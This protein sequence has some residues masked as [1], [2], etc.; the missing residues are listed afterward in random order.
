MKK[1][2]LAAIVLITGSAALIA[3][4]QDPYIMGHIT[5]CSGL[6]DN[7]YPA[8]STNWF[9]RNQHR[10]V[11]YWAYILFAASGAGNVNM[12]NKYFL[13]KNPYELYSGSANRGREDGDN[14]SFENRWISPSGKLICEKILNWSKSSSD[15]RVTVDGKQYV[16]YTFADFIGVNQTFPENGQE[17]I[18]SEKGLYHIDLYINGE[19]ASVTF[20]EM[21]D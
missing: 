10:A 17:A 19:L 20:F 21:K 4:P 12:K 14:Y 16:P 2:L 9:Y 5:T 13:F 8:D 7:S 6:M 18:P 1:V 3:G 15:K 11:Q